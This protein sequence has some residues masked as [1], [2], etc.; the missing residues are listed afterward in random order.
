MQLRPQRLNALQSRRQPLKAQSLSPL[1]KKLE[2]K[3]TTA[4]HS[5]A[6]RV[7]QFRPLA[8]SDTAAGQ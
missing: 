2:I 5:R 7:M 6:A 4:L 8:H 1:N 3:R